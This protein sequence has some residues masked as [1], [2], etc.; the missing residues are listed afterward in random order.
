MNRQNTQKSE[1]EKR[2]RANERKVPRRY[3]LT[4]LKEDGNY[5]PMNDQEFAEFKQTNPHLAKY[6][7]TN[8]EEEDLAPISELPVPEVPESAP[9][10]DMWEKAASRLLTNL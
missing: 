6:F 8:E 10:F 2:A 7:E 3:L 5:E 4:V 1:L 9:I